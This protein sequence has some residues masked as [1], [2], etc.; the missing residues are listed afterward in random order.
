MKSENKQLVLIVD[1]EPNNIRVV[2]NMLRGDDYEIALARSGKEALARVKSN[3]VDLI[4]LDIMMP[5]MD[6]YEVCEH[7]IKDPETKD[8]PV[9]FLTAKTDTDS[10]IEGFK[11]GGQDYITKPF[12]SAEL[13][14]RVR[15]HL[16]LKRNQ[17]MLLHS[18]EQLQREVA[19]RK[20]AEVMLEQALAD[21]KRSN[22][23]LEQ[24]AY[25]VSHDLQEP[26]RMVSSYM[27]LLRQRY[28]GKLDSNADD[29]IGFAVDGASRMHTMIQ[30]LLIYSRVSTRGKPLTPTNCE[31]ILPQA[32]AN[33]KL[34]IGDSGAVVTHDA[35]PTVNVDASQLLR[36]FQ[37][38][39][40]NAIK[41]RGDN[42]PH[43]RLLAEQKG[44]EWEFSVADNG[45][46][47]APE[48]FAR[49]FI[50]FQR[51]HSREE[52]SGTG[53][54]LSVCKKI[55]ERHGGRMWVESEP[56][57]GSTFY[58]TIPARGGVQI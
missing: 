29:F 7:L 2:G 21:L 30:D 47:I 26:L 51:L 41:F 10:I 11:I 24:F 18:N 39:I 6:G 5:G 28:E 38:L 56:G 14:T 23:D 8:I 50:I 54:G 31:D 35:L 43:I 57:K 16:K 17:D 1:D 36:L 55:V 15:T 3:S 19:E 12:N 33:L 32:L 27:E 34:A 20:K 4:L 40:G 42:P 44:D 53:I 25:V 46:G 13:L 45:I 9:I 52:Y 48:Y 58:F 22:T 37:N 49:I